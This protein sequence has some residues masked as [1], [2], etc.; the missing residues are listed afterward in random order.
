MKPD[1]LLSGVDHA[2]C[3]KCGISKPLVDFARN[4]RGYTRKCRDCHAAYSRRR[5]E[6][7]GV[8][9]RERAQAFAY[10]TALRRLRDL[11]RDEFD[12]LYQEERERQGLT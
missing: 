8:Q 7:P 6:Q 12:L 3:Q 10:S 9:E 5:R 4:A 11:H 2:L 1:D